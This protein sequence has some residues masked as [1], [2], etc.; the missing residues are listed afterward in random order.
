M[1][2]VIHKLEQENT[3]LKEKLDFMEKTMPCLQDSLLTGFTGAE[4]KDVND[5]L[6]TIWA[7]YLDKNLFFTTDLFLIKKYCDERPNVLEI[8]DKCPGRVGRWLGWQIVRKWATENKIPLQ[9]VMAEKNARRI[10]E[11][12]GFKP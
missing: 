8:G 1:T 3:K 12:S 11:E 9:K 4:L 2:L 5:N 10:F 7:H 6:K